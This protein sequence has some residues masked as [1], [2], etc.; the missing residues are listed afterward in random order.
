[1]QLNKKSKLN[2]ITKSKSFQIRENNLDLKEKVENLQEDNE[3]K[4]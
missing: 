1:M 2:K 4:Q 3:F